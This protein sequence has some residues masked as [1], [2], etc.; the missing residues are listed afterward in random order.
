[1]DEGHRFGGSY[2]HIPLRFYAVLLAIMLHTRYIGS[3]TPAAIAG[4][5]VNSHSLSGKQRRA[6]GIAGEF[7]WEDGF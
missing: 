4:Y 1:M 7:Y 5:D 6:S 2:R 3:W